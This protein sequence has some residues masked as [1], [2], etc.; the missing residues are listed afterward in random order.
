MKWLKKKR[1]FLMYSCVFSAL[2]WLMKPAYGAYSKIEPLKASW[3]T[4]LSQNVLR[5]KDQDSSIDASNIIGLMKAG[6]ERSE[7]YDFRLLSFLKLSNFRYVAL[8]QIT[9]TNKPIAGLTLES[10]RTLS[11]NNGSYLVVIDTEHNYKIMQQ[12]KIGDYNSTAYASA[13]PYGC[14]SYAIPM[15]STNFDGQNRNLLFVF[16]AKP[17]DLNY[18]EGIDESVDID[19]FDVRSLSKVAILDYLNVNESAEDEG[20]Y[21][22]VD[23]TKL[24]MLS[25]KKEVPAILSWKKT[26]NFIKHGNRGKLV[27]Q[28]FKMYKISKDGELSVARIAESAV[29][30]LLNSNSVKWDDGYP[31]KNYCNSS[32]DFTEELRIKGISEDKR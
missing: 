4:S 7:Y 16:V 31:N 10:R 14:A 20:F 5:V 15:F 32:G 29:M 13:I 23:Y 17:S 19:V 11:A 28:Q 18:S 1:L 22:N 27:A 30:S 12:K 9:L 26:F 21:G 25:G 24:F 2:I 6:I 3:D 8:I